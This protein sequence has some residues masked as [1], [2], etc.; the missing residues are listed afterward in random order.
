MKEIKKKLLKNK[1]TFFK[2]IKI[3]INI[4]FF[5]KQRQE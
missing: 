1:L 5:L 2:K 4:L 3:Y